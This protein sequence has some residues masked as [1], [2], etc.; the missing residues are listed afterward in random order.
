MR[1][2]QQE[3]KNFYENDLGSLFNVEDVRCKWDCDRR[4]LDTAHEAETF[5]PPFRSIEKYYYSDTKCIPAGEFLTYLTTWSA[6]QKLIHT[7]KVN[8]DPIFKIRH[9]LGEDTDRSIR[10]IFPFWMIICKK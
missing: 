2:A 3:L 4:R 5:S 1:K 8:E 6:Y 9:A 10:V 7:D